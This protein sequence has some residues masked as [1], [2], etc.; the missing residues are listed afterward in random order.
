MR[1]SIRMLALLFLIVSSL[2]SAEPFIVNVNPNAGST[3]GGDLV[4]IYGSGFSDIFSVSFG[5]LPAVNYFVNSD[6][7]ISATVPTGLIGPVQ[8]KVSGPRGISRLTQGSFY[9]YQGNW[10]AFVTNNGASTVTPI[11]LSTGVL[12]PAISTGLGTSQI[13]ITP[14]GK[15][16][17]EADFQANTVTP[18]FIS[19]L[20]AGAPIN[21]GNSPAGLAI[22]PNGK[23]LFVACSGS[24]LVLPVDIATLTTEA[25]IA[26]GTT[27]LALAITP[28]GN[29]LYVTNGGSNNVTVVNIP[30]R[31]VGTS[32]AVGT[33]PMG[34]AITP[35]GKRAYVVNYLSSNVTPINIA[36][37][38]AQDPIAVGVYPI[39]IAI[40]PD[41]TT[42]YIANM[43]EGS[44]TPI[45]IAT[46]STLPSIPVGYNPYS[47]AI[48][49]DGNTAYVPNQGSNNLTPI[50]LSTNSAG[51]PIA[52]GLA[53]RGIAITPDQS[54]VASF[55]FS[56][57]NPLSNQ[58]VSFNATASVS[59]VG[60]IATYIWN[61][62][63]GESR[64][65]SSPYV[66]HYYSSYGNYIVTLTVV[67]SAGTS[68]YQV[69][70]GSTMSNNG[71][72]MAQA[73]LY[74]NVGQ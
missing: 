13:V 46:N 32:I 58:P 53:P 33:S 30:T 34:I 9:T 3:N 38:M 69:F 8:V 26:V 62:G 35:N 2:L 63:D 28:D 72:P 50:N 67:N 24:N 65:T 1:F 56:P 4:H 61:F 66:N 37:N 5:S 15:M 40:S 22:T 23:T 39:G 16:A 48:T 19:T 10:L 52:M 71:G 44:V 64:T 41:G 54:P 21:V 57:M 49:P 43:G 7:V 74:V 11:N 73:V 42:A 6:S 14:D 17:F 29:W 60:N 47:I 55:T 31:N 68:N 12:A 18:I 59:P 70:T 45:V 25:P 27:P 20:T 51:S 36:T